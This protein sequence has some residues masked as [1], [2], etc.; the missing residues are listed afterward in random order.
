MKATQCYGCPYLGT[1][2]GKACCRYKRLTTGNAP[3][4]Y[5]KHIQVCPNPNKK[6]ITVM[7]ENEVKQTVEV[8]AE[9][10]ELLKAAKAEKAKREAQEKREQ[11][12]RTYKKL[13][14][15]AISETVPEA[16]CI[17]EMLTRTKDGIM[18]RFRAVI[19]LKETLFVGSK[20]LKDGRYSDTFTNS[21]SNMRVTVGYNTLDAYDDT[22]TAG[23]EMVNQYIESLATD[24]KS[25]QLADMVTTLLRER[26]KA[27]QLKAQNVLR[28]EQMAAES[29]DE[30]F[31]EGMRIIRE[32]YR[33]QK[34]KQFVKVEVKNPETNEW[35]PITMNMTNA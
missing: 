13:V 8:T 22:Y 23:V 14:D 15:D 33:P 25:K 31:I 2:S 4:E 7:K 10:L 32:A 20:Q 21:D 24:D 35:V 11:D 16:H 9:E 17:Q 6:N 28:L 12:L 3:K 26:S 5:L 19:D 34:S 1:F 18:E 27:G 29:K 30:T